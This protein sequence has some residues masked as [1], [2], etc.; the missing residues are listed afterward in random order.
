MAQKFPTAKAAT[1]L[2]EAEIFGD[3]ATCIKWSIT[4]QTLRNYRARILEDGNLL[5]SFELKK[6]M[7]LVGWQQNCAKSLNKALKILDGLMDDA[8][9]QAAMGLDESAAHAGMIRAVA[10]GIKIVGELKLA[11]EALDESGSSSEIS[12]TQARSR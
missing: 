2:A 10:G 9:V 7:L 1:V 5:Q 8:P 6:R 12:E 3:R 4:S 11:G